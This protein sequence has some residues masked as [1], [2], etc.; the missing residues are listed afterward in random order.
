MSM[1]PASYKK[2]LESFVR[3]TLMTETMSVKDLLTTVDEGPYHMMPVEDL[4]DETV[5]AL[6]KLTLR[7][8][9]RR[10]PANSRL[11]DRFVVTSAG[12]HVMGTFDVVQQL[13][14]VRRRYT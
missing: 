12:S 13:P 11:P 9:V 10:L 2:L 1:V 7:G 5:E 3:E 14:R 6:E 8:L 4:N